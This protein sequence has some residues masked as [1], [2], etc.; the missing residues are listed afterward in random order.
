MVGKRSGWII[1]RIKRHI[2]GERIGNKCY[3][4]EACVLRIRIYAE[5]GLWKF[6][7]LRIECGLGKLKI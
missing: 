1:E 4:P 6:S 7:I 2:N 5:S 3:Q